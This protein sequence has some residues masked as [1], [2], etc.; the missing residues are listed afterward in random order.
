MVANLIRPFILGGQLRIARRDGRRL[1]GDWSASL[2][3]NL[4]VGLSG[5]QI[6]MIVTIDDPYLATEV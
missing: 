6:H 5:F 2:K 3:A 1:V 4:F